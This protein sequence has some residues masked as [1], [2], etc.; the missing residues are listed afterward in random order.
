MYRK[1]RP[2]GSHRRL[3]VADLNHPAR[4]AMVG[5]VLQQK[6]LPQPPAV[7]A[8]KISAPPVS[9]SAVSGSPVDPVWGTAVVRA[10]VL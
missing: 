2:I 6:L 7:A 9:G 5:V 4:R 1:N 10:V 3:A 8:G